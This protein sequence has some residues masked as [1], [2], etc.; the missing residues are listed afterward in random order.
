MFLPQTVYFDKTRNTIL[1]TDGAMISSEWRTRLGEFS[2]DFGAGRPVTDDNVEWVLL[3]AD[4]PGKLDP[5]YDQLIGALWYQSPD[6]R[7]RLGVSGL[8]IDSGYDPSGPFDL[9][10][11][12]VSVAFAILS[13]RYDWD[14]WTLAAEYVHLPLEW[15]GFGPFFPFSESDGESF[16]VQAA[17]RPLSRLELMARIERGFA[18]RN[19]RNGERQS[20]QTGGFVPPFDFFDRSWTVGATWH[21]NRNLM[22]RA[23]YSRR[24]GTYALSPRENDPGSLR[25][26]WQLFAAQIALRF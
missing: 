8:S 10:P 23:E 9:G 2:L 13:A 24:E 17:Y 1:S 4:N 15:Q 3:G 22:L 20:A 14:R 12:E 26:D 21:V 5:D 6:E 11:G 7:L 19:D 16:Y 18:D 25:R